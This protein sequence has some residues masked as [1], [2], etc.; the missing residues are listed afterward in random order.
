MNLHSEEVVMA[1]TPSNSIAGTE[2][3][4]SHGMQSQNSVYMNYGNGKEPL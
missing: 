3:K 4:L 1:V 2:R